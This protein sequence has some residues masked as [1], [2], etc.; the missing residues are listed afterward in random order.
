MD[1]TGFIFEDMGL[2]IRAADVVAQDDKVDM[3]FVLGPSEI[4][5]EEFGGLVAAAAPRWGKPAL[6]AWI[7]SERAFDAGA[8]KLRPAGIACYS[9]PTRAAWTMV[10]LAEY[11]RFRESRGLAPWGGVARV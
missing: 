6:V 8:A 4:G 9:D 7:A 2:Y 1:L 10:Q 3:L 11:G 5:P